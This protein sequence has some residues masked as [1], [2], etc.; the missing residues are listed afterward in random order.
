MNAPKSK[1][2]RESTQ[3]VYFISQ[4]YPYKNNQFVGVNIHPAFIR[5]PAAFGFSGSRAPYYGTGSGDG[6]AFRI[7]SPSHGFSYMRPLSLL[8]RG[9]CFFGESPGIFSGPRHDFSG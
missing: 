9:S 3:R 7:A 4:L 5:S 6:P 2:R 1:S 8:F